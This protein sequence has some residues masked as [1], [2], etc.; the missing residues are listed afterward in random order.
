MASRR[1]PDVSPNTRLRLT[2]RLS[3]EPDG[4]TRHVML[5]LFEAF[6]KRPWMYLV[7]VLLLTGLGVASVIGTGR[8]YRSV[9][10]LSRRRTPR[11]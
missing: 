5:N 1:A 4:L 6:F 10:T 11:S 8:E 3:L 2:A 9:G 7:P